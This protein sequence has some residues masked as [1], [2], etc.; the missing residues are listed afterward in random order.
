M[1]YRFIKDHTGIFRAEKMCR[2]FSVSPAGYYSWKR[3]EP[4]IRQRENERLL[5][6]IQVI[7]N[8]SRKTYGSPRVTAM[9]RLDG[10]FYG[11]NR[12]AHLMKDN[13][14][15]AIGKRK[16][17]VTTN[18][19]HSLPVAENLLADGIVATQPDQ[20]GVADITYIA[21][22]EGW[23]Y[24]ATVLDAYSRRVVGWSMADHIR[25]ELV[26][27]AIEQAIMKRNPSPD[28]IH[29]SDRGVQYASHKY[30]ELLSS[31]NMRCSMSGKGNCYDNATME[32]F[33]GSLKSELV[34]RCMFRTRKEAISAIFEYIEA[35][36][37]RRRLHSSLSY[38]SPAE[39]EKRHYQS[40]LLKKAA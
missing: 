18:S 5:F 14:I 34:Y 17:K 1:K 19:R 3:S 31:H 11:K 13:G 4:S 25:K 32:S 38:L 22:G 8:E 16:Y 20:V 37:N 27:D 9:L 15:K 33:Y 21:T 40:Q 23:L 35:F 7:H 26:I 29:H 6:R 2:T 24:L 28:L 10:L 30:R 39:F 12:V 36:Y